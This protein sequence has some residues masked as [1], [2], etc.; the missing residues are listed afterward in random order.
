MEVRWHDVYMEAGRL[1][2]SALARTG[3]LPR[4][5]GGKCRGTAELGS[6]KIL[7]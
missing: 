1:Y 7:V 2:G 4:S 5:E 6:Q 3:H